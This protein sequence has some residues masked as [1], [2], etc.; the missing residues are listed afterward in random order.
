MRLCVAL[1]VCLAAAPALAQDKTAPTATFFETKIR[2][3]LAANCYKC[4]GPQKA[5]S[6]LRV[7]SREAL[8]KGG[9]HG[10]ALVAGDPEGSLLVRAV[11]HKDERKM[12]PKERLSDEVVADLERWIAQGAFWPEGPL[13]IRARDVDAQ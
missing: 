2:P 1:G 12:P 4:H 11:R 5:M 7:D 13:T 3:V 6:G 8:L 10:P 9:K